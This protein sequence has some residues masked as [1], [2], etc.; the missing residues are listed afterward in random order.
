MI[1]LRQLQFALS[2]EQHQHFKR[3]AE[4][5][6]VTPSALSLGIAELEKQLGVG[7][8]ERNN[9]Q[10]IITPEGRAILE[11]AKRIMLEVST[12]V[13]LAHSQDEPLTSPM[14]MGMI[15]TV[16]PF[17]LPVIIQEFRKTY[18]KFDIELC[19]DKTL[20]LIELVRTGQLDTAI[21]A[22]P[23]DIQGLNVYPFWAE[24]F[25][26]VFREGE[27]PAKR[28]SISSEQLIEHKLLLLDEGHCLSD[29][30]ISVCGQYAAERKNFTFYHASLFTLMQMVA[31]GHGTT[32]IP[33]L[34]THYLN[35]IEGR[36]LVAVPLQEKG[37]HRTLAFIV[38]PN[39][40]RVPEIE[41]L[42]RV[43]GEM[44]TRVFGGEIVK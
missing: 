42:R 3:A 43:L 6:K 26:A 5:C 16:A 9:K 10:V 41:L 35:N 15:P 32:V 19:E 8:F 29:H 2:V 4:E 22:L 30:T 1:T 21:V 31:S 28:T 37:P 34:A 27:P 40:V 44:L 11:Q 33:L 17:L 38:R 14:R 24:N 25:F 39:Y 13:N 23:Y 18:P 20:R 36:Q 7:L 12:L